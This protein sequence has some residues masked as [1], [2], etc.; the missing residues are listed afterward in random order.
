VNNK[1]DKRQPLPPPPKK[2]RQSRRAQRNNN[3]NAVITAATAGTADDNSPPSNV[4]ATVADDN[5]MERVLRWLHKPAGPMLETCQKPMSAP[6]GNSRVYCSRRPALVKTCSIPGNKSERQQMDEIVKR[7][8]MTR[9]DTTIS[10]CTKNRHKME[11]H[12]HM[13]SMCLGSG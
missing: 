1:W 4:A 8:T 12:V 5:Y 10:N 11:L 7:P 2:E 9:S 3:E 6:L 13:P